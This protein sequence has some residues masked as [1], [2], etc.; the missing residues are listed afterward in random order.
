M[1]STCQ[2][3]G[4]RHHRRREDEKQVPGTL[5]VDRSTGD[6]ALTGAV[7]EG[8]CAPPVPGSHSYR[9]LDLQNVFG[10]P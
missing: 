1:P 3:A 9:P 4:H 6:P 10:G 5:D 7:S 8:H 2:K